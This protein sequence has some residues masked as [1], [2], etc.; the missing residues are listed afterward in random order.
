MPESAETVT[1]VLYRTTESRMSYYEVH[2]NAKQNKLP[3]T[4]PLLQSDERVALVS[5]RS[6]PIQFTTNKQA[7]LLTSLPHTVCFPDAFS[8]WMSNQ[9]PFYLKNR[10]HSPF[11]YIYIYT[12]LHLVI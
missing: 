12:H 7:V 4:T 2:K 5:L 11:I 10:K 9:S 6:R 1:V 8:Q 3:P